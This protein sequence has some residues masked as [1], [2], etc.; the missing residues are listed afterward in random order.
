MRIHKSL[1]PQTVIG[2]KG[3]GFRIDFEKLAKVTGTLTAFGELLR[4]QTRAT[5]IVARYGGEEYVVLMPHTGLTHGL[6][7]A[8]RREPHLQPRGSSRCRMR[9]P[10]AS[11]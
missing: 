5:E 6:A 4:S 9:R 11:A 1:R 8:E 3:A 10:R 7:S 2:W